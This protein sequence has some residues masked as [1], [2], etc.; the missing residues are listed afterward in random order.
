MRKLPDSE[1]DVMLEIW[2]SK[3]AVCRFDLDAA[4][5]ERNWAPTTIATMLSRLEGK[6]FLESK[7]Q[8]KLKY[9]TPLITQEEYAENVSQ[10]MLENFFGNSLKRFV[11]CMASREN[12]SKEDLAELRDFLENSD[13]DDGSSHG[14]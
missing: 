7:K 2:K 14:N 3:D 10:N 11:A 13:M 9:Y 6:G 12:F 1:L 5:A 4:L 8:G